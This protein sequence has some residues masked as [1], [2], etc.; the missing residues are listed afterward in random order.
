[1]AFWVPNLRVWLGIRQRDLPHIWIAWLEMFNVHSEGFYRT[2]WVIL[3]F[4]HKCSENIFK[5]FFMVLV[6][7][8]LVWQMYQV[9]VCWLK[10]IWKS[11]TIIFSMFSDPLLKKK[12]LI[13]NWTFLC[14][15]GIHVGLWRPMNKE[16]TLEICLCNFIDINSF[17]QITICVFPMEAYLELSIHSYNIAPAKLGG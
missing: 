11:L 7:S 5:A 3:V 12:N 17:L 9:S 10:S 15:V 13:S 4:R 16:I 6:S 2:Q 14:K 8:S 1:M